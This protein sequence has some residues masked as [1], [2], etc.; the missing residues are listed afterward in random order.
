MRLEPD[1]YG[2]PLMAKQKMHI[3]AACHSPSCTHDTTTQHRS[4]PLS[5]LCTKGEPAG[6]EPGKHKPKS[7]AFTADM[8]ATCRLGPTTAAGHAAAVA[9]PHTA[10]GSHAVHMHKEVCMQANT[11]GP[12][13]SKSLTEPRHKAPTLINCNLCTCNML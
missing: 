3:A 5:P 4:Y 9:A 8:Q 6:A 2:H 13:S 1:A 10:G 12:S 7:R 11:P